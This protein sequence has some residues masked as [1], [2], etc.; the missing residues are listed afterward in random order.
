MRFWISLLCL[1]PALAL[2]D[3]YKYVDADGHVT[4][5][6]APTKGA[7]RIILTTKNPPAAAHSHTGNTQEDFPSV[8]KATQKNRDGSRRKILDDELQA[9]QML[10]DSV[11]QQLAHLPKDGQK[12]NELAKQEDLHR[13][14]ITAIKTELSR[15]K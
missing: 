7:I 1:T 9:E 11:R 12:L 4:Y 10:L 5:S 2:A 6:S 3:I 8:N 13:E 14:N 15:L